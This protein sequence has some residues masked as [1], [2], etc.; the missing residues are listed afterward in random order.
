MMSTA[1]PILLI[2]SAIILSFEFAGMYGIGIAAVGM[3]ANTGIQLAVDAYGPI[4]DN[5]GGIAEMAAPFQRDTVLGTVHYSSP[6][7]V[8]SLNCDGR[9]DQFSLAVI[10]YEMLAGKLPFDGKNEQAVTQKDFD[11]LRYTPLQVINPLVPD[12]FDAA[13]AKA[14]SIHPEGRYLEVDEFLFDL[15]H[16][17]KE[18]LRPSHQGWMQENPLRFWQ[19]IAVF[20][21]VIILYLLNQ[22]C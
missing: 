8:L 7:Q 5:A 16:P 17:N 21:L 22:F 18:L 13:V 14:L 9:T 6:E 1:G 4:S 11:K 19:V 20:Q 12:W 3:L 15:K 10:I 2:A